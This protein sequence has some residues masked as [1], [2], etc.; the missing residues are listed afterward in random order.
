MKS[1]VAAALLALC[2]VPARPEGGTCRPSWPG[3]DALWRIVSECLEPSVP[4]Y[5]SRC[6][7]PLAG[8]CGGAAS[9][10]GTTELWAKNADFAA[11]RDIKMCGK[12]CP[13]GFVHGLALPIARVCGAEDSRRP[14]GIW[15]F[16]WEAALAKIPRPDEI[17][18]AVNPMGARSQNQL[19]VH[20]LRFKAGARARLEALRPVAIANL[21]DAWTAAGEHAR[22]AGLGGEFG[23]AVAGAAGGKGFLAAAV[24]GSAEKEFGDA[25]CR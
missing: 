19:H 13:A 12:D 22:R 24:P 2:A 8:A 23:I 7:S 18:L 14:P 11:I 9:C 6:P 10:R 5:C 15:R 1:F 21:D 16:A 20:L 25:A 4:D 3:S 17:L